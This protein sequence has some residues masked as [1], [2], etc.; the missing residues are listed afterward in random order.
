MRR[1]LFALLLSGCLSGSVLAAPASPAVGDLAP[2]FTAPAALSRDKVTLSAQQ[3]KLV[4]LTF[5]ASWCAPCRKELPILE[6]VQRKL[7]KDVAVVL[8]VS[9]QDAKY[10]Q[11]ARGAQKAG[12]QLT[13]LEDPNGKIAAKYGIESIPHLF[14]IGRDGKILAV[15][16]GYGEDSVEHLVRD[17]N[18]ALGQA[19]EPA[20]AEET[21]APQ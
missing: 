2:D 17:I 13:L 3:G 7:G 19:G 11:I 1:T 14:V 21:P 20:A 10:A 18:S 16:T 5:W 9:F 15:H 6:A 12:W 8:A 4:F